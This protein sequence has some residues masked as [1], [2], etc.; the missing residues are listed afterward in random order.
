MDKLMEKKPVLHAVLWI[1]IYIVLVNIGDALSEQMNTAHLATSVLLLALSVVLVL[2]SKKSN[3]IAL[4]GIQKTT[5]HDMRKTLF[6]IPLIL[7]A[8]IQF[9]AGIDRSLSITEIAAACIL[10]IGTGFI[11]EVVFRGFLFQGICGK[12]GVRKAILISGIT[13]GIG[14]IV[15]LLRG[16]DF[17]QM[18]GQIVVAIVVGIVLA[19]LVAVTKNLVPGILF[20]ITFNLSGTITNP[21]SGMQTYVLIAIIAVAVPYAIY[22]L[23]FVQGEKQAE[24]SVISANPMVADVSDIR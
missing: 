24:K 9:A 15:N 10:M 16:Y 5:K 8:F 2:Y 4:Q 3:R 1:M 18:A 20:H 12:S 11:E 17:A 14:H 6:Y 23:R 19:L 21:G 7:L 13:F 22:L